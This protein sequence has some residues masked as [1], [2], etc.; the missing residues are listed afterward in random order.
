MTS[1][2]SR[3]L[4]A[5]AEIDA[6]N[7]NDPRQDMV[8][9]KPRPREVIYS[10]RM[11]DCLSRLYPEASEALRLA[12]RAQ[13]ICRWQIRRDKYPLGRDGY[14]AWRAA[15]RDH[16]AALTSAIMQRHGYAEGE[17][18]QVVKIIRKEQLKRDPESQA[19]ENVVAVVF[20][21]HYLDEFVEG[22]K[23]YDEAKLADILRKTLRKMD[24]VGHAAA[25]ALSLPEPTRRL[26]GMALK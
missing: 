12:A 13:H 5:I 6:T 3:F 2:S 14:N 24:P 19:L 7:A 9:G 17:I 11:S 8:A 22:H 15:C 16:H 25:L 20:V 23:D 10:E 4:A 1:P 21:E 18:A 26:I